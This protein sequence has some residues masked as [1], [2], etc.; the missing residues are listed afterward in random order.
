MKII[1]TTLLMLAAT[2]AIADSTAGCKWRQEG[3][4]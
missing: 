1:V 2:A 4:D 3:H